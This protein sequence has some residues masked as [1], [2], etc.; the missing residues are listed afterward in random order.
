[1]KFRRTLHPIT[2]WLLPLGLSLHFLGYSIAAQEVVNRGM[3]RLKNP[4]ALDLPKPSYTEEARQAG[5]EGIV[6]LQ[7]IVRKD[8]TANNFKVIKSLGYGLD[9]SAISTIANKWRF[10]PATQNGT[11]IDYQILIEVSFRLY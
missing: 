5:I 2:L 4:Q 6:L 7:V 1:M 3:E 11:P 9:E 10:R 8:G